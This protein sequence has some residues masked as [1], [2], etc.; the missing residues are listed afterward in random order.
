MGLM[1]RKANREAQVVA[2]VNMTKYIC[3]YHVYPVHITHCTEWTHPHSILEEF[4]FNFRYVRLW[5]LGFAREK[6]LHNL[7]TVETLIRRRVLRR[8]IWVCTVCQ[9]PFLGFSRQQW[10]KKNKYG[11]QRKIWS[12][13]Y[14]STFSKLANNSVSGQRGPWSDCAE[15]HVDLDPHRLIWV[16]AICPSILSPWPGT[17]PLVATMKKERKKDRKKNRGKKERKKKRRKERMI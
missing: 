5:D 10:I 7:Q 9:I 17:F 1:S 3:I 2:L 12:C 15:A 13:I 6:W 4:N 16:L 8:L 11:Q 14:T